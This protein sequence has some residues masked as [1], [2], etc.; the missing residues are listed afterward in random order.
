MCRFHTAPL[1]CL[2]LTHYDILIEDL[3]RGKATAETVM[4]FWKLD[5]IQAFLFIFFFFFFVSKFVTCY[6]ILL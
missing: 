1:F 4:T 3:E 6:Q 2:C 5:I